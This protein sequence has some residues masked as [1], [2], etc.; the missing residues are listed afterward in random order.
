MILT[1]IALLTAGLPDDP[2]KPDAEKQICKME[3]RT[4][5]RF[6]KKTCR[7]RAQWEAI[8]EASRREAAESFNKP[9]ISIEKG[10]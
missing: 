6:P 8:T 10:S 5:T 7:T 3:Q 1:T 9:V 4:G 2:A